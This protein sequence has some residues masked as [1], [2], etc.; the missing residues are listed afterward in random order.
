MRRVCIQQQ[1]S[2]WPPA[3]QAKHEAQHSTRWLL[4]R[5][6]CVQGC[7]R[8]HSSGPSTTP[9]L[10][11]IAARTACQDK[12][13]ARTMATAFSS[14]CCC[15]TATVAGSRVARRMRLQGPTSVSVRNFQVTQAQLLW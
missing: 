5:P 6:C 1:A 15:A 12:G 10:L 14:A 8:W 2:T 4:V 9:L 11:A 3:Q 7:W 13:V